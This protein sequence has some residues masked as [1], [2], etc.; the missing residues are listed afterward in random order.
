MHAPPGSGYFH[1]N[2][3]E[4]QDPSPQRLEKLPGWAEPGAGHTTEARRVQ[5]VLSRLRE[6]LRDKPLDAALAG[7]LDAADEDA[8]K[9]QATVTRQVVVFSWG[10]LDDLS[11]LLAALSDPK[12]PDVR[13]TA[14]NALRHWIGRG[15]GQDLELYNFLVKHEKYAPTQAE[16]VLQLLHS[17][18]Q[19]DRAETYQTLIEYLRSDKLAV[20][21][22]A[23]W[24]LDRLAPAGRSIGYDA[25]A[26]AAERES[27]VKKWKE[28]IPD[29]QLPPK[30]K[31]EGK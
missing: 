3:V 9:A 11:R 7:L 6:R 16:V 19:R 14:V 13:E 2:S 23:R 22:L 28:L 30:P 8:D 12:H 20:R 17:P 5:E 10:A 15:A 21:E 25:A 31:A 27:A 26:P 1:W 24:H 4:G 29:G 18:F